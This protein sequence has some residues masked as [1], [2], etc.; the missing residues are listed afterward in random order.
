MAHELIAQPKQSMMKAKTNHIKDIQSLTISTK[1]S[2]KYIVLS[3]A[4]TCRNKGIQSLSILA[5]QY[6]KLFCTVITNM[7]NMKTKMSAEN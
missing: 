2:I 7:E 1:V 5:T 4:N 6:G 3:P